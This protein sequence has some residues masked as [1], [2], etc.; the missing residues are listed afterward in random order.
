MSES[1]TNES[2]KPEAY[3]AAIFPAFEEIAAFQAFDYLG[4]NKD[5][6][7]EQKAKFLAGELSNP[8]LD[9]PKLNLEGITANEKSL[10]EMKSAILSGESN[11]VM[12][13]A[14][15]WR[16]NEKIA[17]IRLL[18]AA[19]NGDMRR[20]ARYNSFIYG[21]PSREVFAYTLNGIRAKAETALSSTNP[22]LARSAQELLKVLPKT[23]DPGFFELPEDE[24]IGHVLNHTLEE[25]GDLIEVDEGKEKYDA[26]EIVAEFSKALE[27]M[28]NEDWTVQIDENATNVSAVRRT[29]KV[30]V[31]PDKSVDEKGMKSLK[32]EEIATHVARA[33]NGKRS[34]LMLL[35]L[36]LDR[37]DAGE[38]G[39]GSLRGQAMDEGVEDFSG[40]SGHLAVSLAAGLDGQPK[41]F[42][43]VFEIMEKYFAFDN[44]TAGKS[45]IEAQTKAKNMAWARCVRTFR[46][47][48]CATPGA[49]FMKDIVYREGN[50]GVWELMRQKPDEML[51]FNI[52]KYDPTNPRHIW[53]LEQ[54]GI[55]DEDLAELEK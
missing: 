40:L 27:K 4:G 26:E 13:Q 11:E 21:E 47:S 38:E 49:C 55:S 28:D 22:A 42:R 51:R 8:T 41:D 39:V 50:I 29:Q 33:I 14:Y 48:D 18:K 16:I 37:Y 35:S 17:E 6:R 23:D 25:L 54:L 52:G 30:N 19:A 12:K 1:L 43:Q 15:R 7:N 53:V 3:D 46:G 5:F 34:K 31:P 2:P 45:D 9:Y 24:L 10:L 36:G 32:L 44:M 20:F